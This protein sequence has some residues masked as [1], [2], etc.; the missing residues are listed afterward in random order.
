MASTS[1]PLPFPIIFFFFFLL[2]NSLHA[3]SFS[4]DLIHRDSPR[5]PF[6]N[7]SESLSDRMSRAI[8][9]SNS[10]MDYFQSTISTTSTDISSN[11]LPNGG[12]YL[13]TI[14]LGTPPVQFL[15]I[16]DTGSDLI[17]TQC[18]PCESCY[19]QDAPL[20]DPTKSSTYGDLS[21]DSSQC[22]ALPR[23]SCI[24]SSCQYSYRYGDRQSYTKGVLAS[25]TVGLSSSE[26][27]KIAFGCGHNN[28]GTF[29]S[30]GSGLVGL[31]GGS[32]SLISQLSSSIGGKFA[33]C[34]VP[35]TKN[36]ASSRMDFGDSAVVSGNGV[37]S[38]PL[39]SR[40]G[41]ETFFFLTLQKITVGTNSISLPQA[42][43]G[44]IIIDSGTTLTYLPTSVYQQLLSAL[45]NSINL[46]PVQDP[47]QIGLELCYESGTGSNINP[48]LKFGFDG[49]EVVL[50]FLNTFIQVDQN[51]ACAAF[52]PS[53]SLSI[54]G[55][56]AQQNFKIGVDLI[57]R[58]SP[59]SPFY[60]SSETLSGRMLRAFRH[61]SSRVN[62]YLGTNNSITLNGLAS[63]VIPNVADYLM[64]ISL[65][66]PPV[67]I[68][69][70][71]DTGSDLIWTQCEPCKSCYDQDA[72]YFNPKKSSTYR[73]L[74]CPSNFCSAI[75]QASCNTNKTCDYAYSY[76][77]MSYTYGILA[78]ETLTMGSTTG[79][80][81]KIPKVAFGCGHT[82]GGTFTSHGAGLVGLGGGPLSLISQLGSS[83]DGKFAY[84]LVPL[85]QNT[86]SSHMDFG[87]S[88]I[89]TGME[90]SPPLSSPNKISVGGKT[91]SLP[92][93]E[94]G[95]II[96][97]SGTTCSFL[98][99]SIYE[100]LLSLLKNAINLT[101]ARDPTETLDLCYEL[102]KDF[103]VPDLKFDF[104]GAQLVLGSLNTF[105][106]INDEVTCLAFMASDSLS[107]FGNVAQQN[108]KVGYDLQS[109]KVSFQPTDCTKH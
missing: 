102:G 22:L 101:T 81:V 40:Q 10:R 55:N 8:R 4:I 88:A 35:F 90:Q 28:S 37:V 80:S 19:H 9:R 104:D 109:K 5:S 43:Q 31:G 20:F 99:T 11:V 42:A 94:K 13:M 36:T 63:K 68:L 84:C 64:T 93:A 65:G 72:P 106:S 60:N 52:G 61:S 79:S 92:Q 100:E 7:L 54:Y 26:F 44:N 24:D 14:S 62:H 87:D 33:Y 66:T 18:S 45:K 96:I 73:V 98:P 78:A 70:V 46:Q 23:S 48:E 50:G 49:A 56:V 29:S 89:V 12:N 21:C 57:H 17:W 32:L 27:P 15:A 34:L 97:D 6:Y 77:D 2:P 16:A 59:R 1:L 25:E 51:V 85:H 38:T 75:P 41:L 82:N 86:A 58:D 108:F 69:A 83:I 3:T 105:I 74:P 47:S 91:I 67:Q 95:N 30:R 76:G 71:A 103:K 39:I 53:Q 107:I